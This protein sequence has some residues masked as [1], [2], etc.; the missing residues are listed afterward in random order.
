[1]S[2]LI[3]PTE[4]LTAY[5]M[6]YVEPSRHPIRLRSITM[7]NFWEPLV[8]FEAD[9]HTIKDCPAFD[10]VRAS[11][12]IH[13]ARNGSNPRCG[14]YGYDTEQNLLM[15]EYEK[16]AHQQLGNQYV[17]VRG[18]MAIWGIV[19]QHKYGYISQFAYPIDF[20]TVHVKAPTKLPYSVSHG[21]VIDN[22][23]SVSTMTSS[24][25]RRISGTTDLLDT[26]SL[27]LLT[28]LRR[29][30]LNDFEQ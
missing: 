12:M 30:Y 4:P 21:T 18:S 28:V 15:Q 22:E 7:D 14:I 23:Y 6:W 17:I 5:R 2:N 27:P 8:P 25:G 1:M 11:G 10:D 3:G 16:F 29:Y 13:T 24:L 9:C 26:M 19:L 20:S